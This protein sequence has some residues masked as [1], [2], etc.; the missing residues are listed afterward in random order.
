MLFSLGL[1]LALIDSFVFQTSLSLLSIVACA[2]GALLAGGG[3]YI[4]I[5]RLASAIAEGLLNPFARIPKDATSITVR[6][7]KALAQREGKLSLNGL[8]TLSDEAAK[9]LARHAGDLGLSG[10]TTLSNEAAKALAQHNGRLYLDGL[11]T[12]SDEAAKALSRHDGLLFLDGLTKLSDEAAKALSRHEDWLLLNGL[13]TLS[14]EA[15]KALAQ[16]EGWLS[17]NG[18]TT[19]SDEAAKALARHA[20]DLC[21]NGLTKLSDEAAKALAR[22]AGDLGLN[23]LTTLSPDAAKALAQREGEL[24]LNG[25]TTL[26]DE[27]AKALSQHKGALELNGLT[28]LSDEAAKA[29]AQQEGWLSLNGLTTLSDEA[30]WALAQHKGTLDLNLTTLSDE[31]AKAL[32][33]HEGGYLLLDGLTTLSDEAAKALAQHK[34][35]LALNGLTTLSDA[36]QQEMA[37]CE[38]LL[39]L[40][41]LTTLTAASLAGRLAKEAEHHDS[42][43][44]F[45]RFCKSSDEPTKALL[46]HKGDLDLNGLTT[47]SN[48]AARA[49]S[50]HD[51]SRWLSLRGL[52]NL[53]PQ[54]ISILRRKRRLNI[55]PDF[56]RR[57]RDMPARA[58]C[59]LFWFLLALGLAVLIMRVTVVDRPTSRFYTVRDVIVYLAFLSGSAWF[60]AELTSEG[61]SL[62]DDDEVW[63]WDLFG[64]IFVAWLAGVFLGMPFLFVM[65]TF[66]ITGPLGPIEFIVATLVMGLLASVYIAPAVVASARNHPNKYAIMLLN[67]LAGWM[68]I[69]WVVALV[70]AS[71][72]LQPKDE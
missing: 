30:A 38:F 1:T 46:Q 26:S 60:V 55:S 3:L 13:T 42:I 34:G 16:H 59:G 14:D 67:Y 12:L 49:L 64:V 28:T 18:L 27:A 4:E 61:Y 10:L 50:R 31:A 8:T 7:A 11:T 43:W 2:L 15:A 57:R 29:L 17:L 65:D 51:A 21:L 66:G 72:S 37:K 48:E 23:G 70:W 33:Q 56:E 32:A 36:A 19:L 53:T 68:F 25:L 20:G 9:A 41:G 44:N 22:H 47:L 35:S 52:T 39:R 24:S 5:L 69:P 54:L 6:Q 63:C 62:F 58:L 45:L 40:T 71:L